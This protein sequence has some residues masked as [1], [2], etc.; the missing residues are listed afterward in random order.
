MLVSNCITLHD[1]S[2][3][4]KEVYLAVAPVVSDNNVNPDSSDTKS[5]DNILYRPSIR[6]TEV[7]KCDARSSHSSDFMYCCRSK[8][9]GVPRAVT[10]NI[11]ARSCQSSRL[12]RKLP[13]DIVLSDTD[14]SS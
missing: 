9:P 14:D 7:R 3:T 12:K 11:G 8:R 4:R 1:V 2:I 5:L 10:Y 13:Q 6:T